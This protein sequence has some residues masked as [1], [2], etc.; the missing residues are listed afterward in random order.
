MNTPVNTPSGKRPSNKKR[1]TSAAAYAALVLGSIVSL[2]PFV[3]LIRSALMGPEQIFTAPPE[4]IPQPF[5]WSNF[6][7][8]LTVQP[9]WK[10]FLNT[11]TLEVLTVSGTV[12]T[13]TI[14]AFSFARLRWWGRDV[15][16]G[17]LLTSLMMPYI[18][19]LIP[20]FIFWQKLGLV[21]TYVPLFL[22]AWFGGGAFNI[23]LLRQFFLTIPR[24]FDEAA[25]LDGATP[26]QVLFKIILPLSRPALLV[27]A[28]FS[29]IGV[30]ND[31]LGP[32][33]YLQDDSMFTLA[34]GLA[35]FKGIYNAQWGYLMAA[36][37]TVVAPIIALYFFTQR[38][39]VEGIAAT[40]VKG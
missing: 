3:W 26:L 22:P 16:F 4:W 10:Y 23:F 27:V 13:S 30:W 21:G 40:G 34:L 19:T 1:Q 39:F 24:D 37:A 18:V 29:F 17:I 8:S 32:L 38:Y 11:M 2:F 33:I 28:I 36:S 5:R 31:F 12:I 35:T 20:T 6:S 7:E 14:T 9:F 15:V 25:Y